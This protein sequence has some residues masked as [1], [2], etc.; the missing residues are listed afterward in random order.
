[1]SKNRI[2]SLL[3]LVWT[4]TSCLNSNY[5]ASEIEL[6]KD[7]ECIHY[8]EEIVD[9][10]RTDTLSKY[11]ISQYNSPSNQDDHKLIIRSD[12]SFNSE[13]EYRGLMDFDDVIVI[14]IKVC[15]PNNQHR[16]RIRTFERHLMI[17]GNWRNFDSNQILVRKNE[18][19][20][21]EEN[22]N[23][24]LKLIVTTFSGYM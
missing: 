6:K 9:H 8:Y 12:E 20:I 21:H 16:T 22:E 10:Y 23:D 19:I 11:V 5:K 13:C 15:S 1:M 14:E 2:I 7:R 18:K 17:F 24:S 4:I 3:L